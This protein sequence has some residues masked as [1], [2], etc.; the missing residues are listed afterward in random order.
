[1]RVFKFKM[2][3]KDINKLEYE[4]N[5]EEKS[6]RD[7]I[8]F[9]AWDKVDLKLREVVG[10]SFYHGAISTKLNDEEYLQD[11][12][13]RFDLMQYTGLTDKNGV[14]IYE[15]DIITSEDNFNKGKL[16]YRYGCFQIK[17]G[18]E[19]YKLLINTAYPEVIGNI[20]QHK[21]LLKENGL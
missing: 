5:I 20:Y 9:R 19:K 16:V 1:M 2:C 12:S 4:V 13:D 10:I 11:N 8:K 21:D 3:D 6:E 17:Y 18:R 14:E 7:E 15:G